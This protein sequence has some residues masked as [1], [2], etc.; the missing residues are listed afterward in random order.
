MM[1][2]YWVFKEIQLMKFCSEQVTSNMITIEPFES[3]QTGMSKSAIFGR[4]TNFQRMCLGFK[5]KFW[6]VKSGLTLSNIDQLYWQQII[7]ILLLVQ[8]HLFQ[9]TVPASAC[10][11]G[12]TEA[13]FRFSWEDLYPLCII[14]SIDI[15]F[16]KYYKVEYY[17]IYII[18]YIVEI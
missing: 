17:P 8:R 18:I 2:N 1:R 13:S 5:F 4:A 10:F 7:H 15:L 9:F 16:Y 6:W 12:F 3:Y 14:N 11:F